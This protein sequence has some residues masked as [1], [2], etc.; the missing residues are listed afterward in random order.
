MEGWHTETHF[1]HLQT[2]TLCIKTKGAI[3]FLCWPQPSPAGHTRLWCWWELDG[4]GVSALRGTTGDGFSSQA[5]RAGSA[6]ALR[7]SPG[8]GVG[9]LVLRQEQDPPYSKQEAEP[10]STLETLP[11]LQ[12][13]CTSEAFRLWCPGSGSRETWGWMKSLQHL[14]SQVNI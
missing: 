6:A 2:S 4:A 10:G 1:L 13:N 14:G 5:W 12:W 7:V 3:T 11:G 8:H 9:P